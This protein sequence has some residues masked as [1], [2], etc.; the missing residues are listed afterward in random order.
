MPLQLFGKQ[1][2]LQP[3]QQEVGIQMAPIGHPLDRTP[4]GLLT[5]E[6]PNLCPWSG[7]WVCP[8]SG[9]WVTAWGL[10]RF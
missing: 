5:P 10:D 9:S 6:G 7:S 8:W 3:A 4:Q 1:D 2:R